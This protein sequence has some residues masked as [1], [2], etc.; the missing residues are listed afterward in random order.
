MDHLE[1]MKNRKRFPLEELHKYIGQHVAWSADNS[2][3][4][5]S[6]RDLGD[7]FAQLER[8]GIRDY[9]LEYIPEVNAPPTLT[10]PCKTG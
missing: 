6:S 9:I 7:L 8:Q 3:V 10:T 4:L 2:R 1:A 5:G